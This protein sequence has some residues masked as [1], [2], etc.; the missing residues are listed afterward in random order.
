MPSDQEIVEQL[1]DRI[2]LRGVFRLIWDICR[3]KAK[4]NPRTYNYPFETLEYLID[5]IGLGA[6]VLAT[7]AEVCW[8]KS[9]YIRG[10]R[11]RLEDKHKWWEQ[12]E[13]RWQRMG[14]RL[15]KLALNTSLGGGEIE[16]RTP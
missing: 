12:L 10:Q 7:I 4:T 14:D 8:T 6:G 13:N 2:G 1:I 3:K 15:E 11:L 16:I 9:D 5:E